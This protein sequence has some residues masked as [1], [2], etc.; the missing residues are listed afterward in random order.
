MPTRVCSPRPIGAICVDRRRAGGAR[1]RTDPRVGLKPGFKDAGVAAR[2]ME[3][4]SSLPKPAGFFDP[5]QPAGAPA[6]NGRRCEAAGPRRAP[7]ARRG[8]QRPPAKPRRTSRPPPERP[9]SRRPDFAN[10]DLAFSGS[11]CSSA[12]STASTPTTSR[13][14]RSRGC[15]RRS[16][17]RAARATSRFTATCCSCR[18]SRRAAARLRHAGRRTAV[19]AERFRGVRIFD[20]TD[21]RKPKQVAAV[22]TCRGSHTHTLVPIPNDKENLY[23]YGSGTGAVRSGEELAGCS[24]RIRRRTRTP[25]S[26]AST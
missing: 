2:N 23:V 6:A 13:T 21:M 18:S 14:R 12:T 8:T 1:P 17:A 10:S 20:I 26:S 5:K 19:S 25:R 16:S 24:A 11:T 9:R 15:S 7:P 22:Q 4:V 3:L